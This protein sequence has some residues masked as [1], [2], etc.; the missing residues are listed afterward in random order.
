MATN[1]LKPGQKLAI[2]NN[3]NLG[4]GVFSTPFGLAPGYDGRI[5]LTIVNLSLNTV[6]LSV[7]ADGGTTWVP[8]DAAGTQVSL[9]T[10]TATSVNLSAGFVYALSSATAIVAGT[11]WVGR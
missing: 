8:L 6:V 1:A 10:L 2:L 5:L 9:A 11:I 7:S 3:A 4:S